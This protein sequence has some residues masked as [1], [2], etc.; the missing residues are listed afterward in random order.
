MVLFQNRMGEFRKFFGKW[1]KL[2]ERFFKICW[3]SIDTFFEK[4]KV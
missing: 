3:V 1:S 4:V 2:G